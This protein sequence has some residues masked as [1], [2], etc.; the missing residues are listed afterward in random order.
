MNRFE[1]INVEWSSLRII[2]E[3]LAYCRNSS[4]VL[5]HRK[6]FQFQENQ[7]TS[8]LQNFKPDWVLFS[9]KAQAVTC[10]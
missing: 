1:Y 3:L 8:F 7:F 2:V 4:F 5:K 9:S 6:D 10:E